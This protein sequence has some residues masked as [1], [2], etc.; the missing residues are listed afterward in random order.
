MNHKTYKYCSMLYKLSLEM[1]HFWLPSQ[2][3]LGKSPK[4]GFSKKSKMEAE[5]CHQ[6]L[7]AVHVRHKLGLPEGWICTLDVTSQ[8]RKLWSINPYVTCRVVV[9]IIGRTVLS[10][11]RNPLKVLDFFLVHTQRN[12]VAVSCFNIL[13]HK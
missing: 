12:A 2:F 1:C 10:L 3:G 11:S 8:G 6:N 9:L 13:T 4:V 7:M 5:L